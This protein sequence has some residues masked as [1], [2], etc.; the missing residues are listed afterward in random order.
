MLYSY[1]DSWHIIG[2]CITRFGLVINDRGLYL[3]VKEIGATHRK[4]SLLFLT[5]NEGAMM[6]FLGLDAERYGNGFQTLDEIFR[7]ATGSRFFRRRFFEKEV[8]GEKERRMREK[9]VMYGRFALEW[10]PKHS[11]SSLEGTNG[12]EDDDDL[13]G[14]KAIEEALSTFG[15]REE[16]A[17]MI[18]EHRIRM[19]RDEMWK[20]V[21]RELP[22]E[23]HELGRALVALKKRLRW[24]KNEIV[25]LKDAKGMVVK[26]MEVR[27]EEAV[28]RVVGWCLERWRGEGGNA[29]NK[30]SIPG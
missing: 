28:G 10:L 19:L 1:G 26:K 29:A 21:T 5:D 22:L 9:R 30:S 7:W 3:R 14:T 20:R 17:R 11:E 12:R 4:R 6:I 8:V 16:Y 2:V 27:D 24:D 25:E 13:F 18:E 23:G 15:K